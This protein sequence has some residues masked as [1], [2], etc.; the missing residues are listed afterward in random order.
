LAEK[1]NVNVISYQHLGTS[2]C[3]R[4]RNLIFFLEQLSTLL[5]TFKCRLG[6]GFSRGGFAVGGFAKLLKLEQ[7]LF[8]HPV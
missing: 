5:S 4:S 2:N 6:Y 1:Q 7:V 3:F 8:F